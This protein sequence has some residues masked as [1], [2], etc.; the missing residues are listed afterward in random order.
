LVIMYP[1]LLLWALSLI[2]DIMMRQTTNNSKILCVFFI[3]S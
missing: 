2:K 3:V 1:D